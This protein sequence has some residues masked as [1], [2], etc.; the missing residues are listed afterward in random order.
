MGPHVI[1]DSCMLRQLIYSNS[2]TSLLKYMQ[3]GILKHS[4]PVMNMFNHI[5]DFFMIR[6][7][8]VIIRFLV[9]LQHTVLKFSHYNNICITHAP[10]VVGWELWFVPCDLLL[11]CIWHNDTT[12]MPVYW[13]TTWSGLTEMGLDQ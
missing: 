13:I 6:P 1:R 7:L 9:H 12:R 5:E 10:T 11:I 3:P 2:C 4:N 8:Q